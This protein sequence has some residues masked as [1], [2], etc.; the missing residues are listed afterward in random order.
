TGGVVCLLVLTVGL[1][2][3]II[4][5]IWSILLPCVR[6]PVCGRYLRGWDKLSRTLV[7]ENLARRTIHDEGVYGHF[8]DS[9]EPWRSTGYITGGGSTSQIT[10]KVMTFWDEYQCP[11]CKHQWTLEVKTEHEDYDL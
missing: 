4:L 1:S 11:R 10:V 2:V 6:C 7:K 9:H 5:L 3:G 8:Y